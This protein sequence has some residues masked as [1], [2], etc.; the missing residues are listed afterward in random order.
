M[1]FRHELVMPLPSCSISDMVTKTCPFVAVLANPASYTWVNFSVSR[2]HFLCFNK[3]TQ[4]VSPYQFI[5]SL[6]L[7]QTRYKLRRYLTSS[8]FFHLRSVCRGLLLLH[9]FGT[10]SEIPA[11]RLTSSAFGQSVTFVPQE[12][13]GV[14]RF[15]VD[16][17]SCFSS[18]EVASGT[19]FF[20]RKSRGRKAQGQVPSPSDGSRT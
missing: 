18:C 13:I 11:L 15:K 5:P 17:P 8:A 20:S 7:C 12:R 1:C 4:Q 19:F 6:V 9:H 3:V 2:R 10:S 14:H 16:V